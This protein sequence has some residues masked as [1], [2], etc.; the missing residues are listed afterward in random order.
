M[1]YYNSDSLVRWSNHERSYEAKLTRSWIRSKGKRE[2]YSKSSIAHNLQSG[3]AFLFTIVSCGTGQCWLKGPQSGWWSQIPSMYRTIE[4]K[5]NDSIP[6]KEEY[7][8]LSEEVKISFKRLKNRISF[9]QYHIQ[10]LHR[11]REGKAIYSNT[12][13]ERK[14]FM[15]FW[16][17]WPCIVIKGSGNW[18]SVSEQWQEQPSN[19][20]TL[21]PTSL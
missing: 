20:H 4:Q 1:G 7:S 16:M 13:L 15:P 3:A 21:T 18:D 12:K 19:V 5:D 6:R 2:E 14:D 10:S 17:M 11:E 9:N 8:A